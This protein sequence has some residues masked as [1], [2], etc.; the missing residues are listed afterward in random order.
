[1]S[2]NVKTIAYSKRL[3]VFTV[4]P[5]VFGYRFIAVELHAKGLHVSERKVWKLCSQAG[6]FSQILPKKPKGKKAGSAIGDDLLQRHF[7]AERPN[8][9]W[10]VD[11]IEHWTG[12]GK[13]YVCALKDVYSRRIVGWA[14]GGRMTSRLAVDALDDAMRQRR[15]PPKGASFVRILA[16]NSDVNLHLPQ[17][18][19]TTSG[20]SVSNNIFHS[21]W[22]I[23]FRKLLVNTY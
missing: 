17:P 15:Y 19:S 9:A 20:K 10:V 16:R 18:K 7:H 8:V 4:M 22:S 1:M 12:T 3:G 14:T 2:A 11:I 5:L 6:I 23:A 21:C 13:V